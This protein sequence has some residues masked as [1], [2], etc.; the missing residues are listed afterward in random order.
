[1]DEYWARINTHFWEWT[2][3]AVIT[4]QVKAISADVAVI[5]I[6]HVVTAHGI[7]VVCLVSKLM[8]QY[9]MQ[10][11]FV[12]NSPFHTT[13]ITH[14]PCYLLLLSL[15]FLFLQ[16]ANFGKGFLGPDVSPEVV[17]EFVEMCHQMRVLNSVRDEQIGMPITLRQYL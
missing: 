17:N 16:S 1:V 8:I 11:T 2:L 14:G 4:S 13:I 10:L 15:V 6:L 3:P 5:T 7:E 9:L 12:R